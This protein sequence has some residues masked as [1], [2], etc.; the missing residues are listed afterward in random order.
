MD[1]KPTFAEILISQLGAPKEPFGLNDVLLG[2]AV[3]TC[4]GSY[5]AFE[6]GL[7]RL[8]KRALQRLSAKARKP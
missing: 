4:V 3:I 1:D 8:L 2:L 6:Y 7:I 5:L